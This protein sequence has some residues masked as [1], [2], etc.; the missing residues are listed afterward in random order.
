MKTST[1]LSGSGMFVSVTFAMLLLLLFVK[2]SQAQKENAAEQ[3]GFAAKLT[4]YDVKKNYQEK[5]RK[6]LSEYVLHSLRMESNVMSEAYYE[7]ENPNIIWL[8]ERWKNKTELDRF[9]SGTHFNAIEILAKEALELPVKFIFVKDLEPLSKQQWRKTAAKQDNPLTV[10][11]FVDAKPGTQQVFED[12]YHVAM[13]QFRGEAGVVTYQI[14]QLEEDDTQFVTYEKFR[15]DE[16]FQYHLSFPPIQPVLDYL[17]TSI[18][19]QPFQS[20]LHNL[21]E[22]APLK[23]E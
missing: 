19:K 11:L 6:T 3:T 5:F 23:R 8:I 21:I 16:A 4:R 10:M 1:L 17:Q 7:K 2:T 12:V 14:S 22:F 18:K 9:N 13:P 20:G 15:D